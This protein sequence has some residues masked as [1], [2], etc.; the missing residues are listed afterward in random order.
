MRSFLKTLDRGFDRAIVF[1]AW[2]AGG[3]MMFA[4]VAVCVDVLMRYF[5]NHPLPWVLQISEYILLYIP[6]LA[7]AYVLREESHI[8]IDILLN[9]LGRRTQNRVNTVTSVLGGAVLLVLAY[10]GTYITVDYYQRSV[11][12]I[13]YLKIPEF[14]V[15]A[16]IPAGCFLFAVQ[17]LR[18]AVEHVREAREDAKTK[19]T[20]TSQ[21]V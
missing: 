13:K 8:R 4:L 19:G 3:L 21:G 15:I 7:A 20:A 9:R 18:R 1:C 2:I 5:F 16:V 6:F 14:L 10:Y 11:P 12:T 17:F